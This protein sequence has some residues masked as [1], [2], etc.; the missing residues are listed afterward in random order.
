MIPAQGAEYMHMIARSACFKNG[1]IVFRKDARKIGMH[2][3]A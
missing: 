3:A 2:A 1:A